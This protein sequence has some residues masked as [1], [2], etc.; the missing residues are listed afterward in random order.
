MGM[1][2]WDILMSDGTLFEYIAYAAGVA[3]VAAFVIQSVRILKTKNIS[4]LSSYMYIMYSLALICWFTYGVYI[5]CWPLAI[6]N[7]ITFIFTFIILLEILYYDEEDKIERVRRDPLTYVFNKKYYESYLPQVIQNNHLI[8]SPFCILIATIDN[9][10][11]IAAVMGGKYKNRA[12]KQTA[13]ALEKALRDNDFVARI[14]DN[15]F[16]IY[17]ANVSPDVAQSVINRVWTSVH[18]LEIRKSDFC[19]RNIDFHI[20][21]CTSDMAS[22]LD[23]FTKLAYAALK[24]TS[25]KT[26]IVFYS[27]KLQ[28]KKPVLTEKKAVSAKPIKKASAPEKKKDIMPHKSAKPKVKPKTSK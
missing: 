10:D 1:S 23:E 17:I 6:A 8:K 24:Q 16:A 26:P 12:L 19:K 18:G 3:T 13:K 11:N 25:T 9:L 7:F 27:K 20:G 22:T 5:E 14:D 2:F 28:E 21:V 4:G 15:I